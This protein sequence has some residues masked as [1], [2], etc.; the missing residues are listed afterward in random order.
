MPFVNQFGLTFNC[1]FCRKFIYECLYTSKSSKTDDKEEL[2]E[3]CQESSCKQPN[4]DGGR[5]NPKEFNE[6]GRSNEQ[7]RPKFYRILS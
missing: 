7:V 1:G 5:P 2:R 3:G 4:S 6:S